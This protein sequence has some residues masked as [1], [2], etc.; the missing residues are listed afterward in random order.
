MA[1]WLVFLAK[2][3]SQTMPS[4]LRKE[5]ILL[6]FMKF[7]VLSFEHFCKRLYWSWLFVCNSSVFLHHCSSSQLSCLWNIYLLPLPDELSQL[8]WQK[9]FGCVIPTNQHQ[10]MNYHNSLSN[11]VGEVEVQSN[12]FAWGQICNYCAL[13]SGFFLCSA[14]NNQFTHKRIHASPRVRSKHHDALISCFCD[15]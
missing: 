14:S 9:I 12:S 3:N 13:A 1:K 4:P 10:R 5:F 7:L 15:A 6:A 8:F 11:A 2:T